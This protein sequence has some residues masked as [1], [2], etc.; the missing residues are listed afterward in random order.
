MPDERPD[1]L[2]K[3]SLPVP[4]PSTLCRG[5]PGILLP[6]WPKVGGCIVIDWT[7]LQIRGPNTRLTNVHGEQRRTYRKAH[8]GVDPDTSLVVA[9]V[10][11]SCQTHDS[12]ALGTP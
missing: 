6:S 3:V 9:G 2:A 8:L 5:R 11:L 4:D 1:A 7:G 12:Q 10:V